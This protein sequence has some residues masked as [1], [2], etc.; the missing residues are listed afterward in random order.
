[1]ART[2]VGLLELAGLDCAPIGPDNADGAQAELDRL[3]E[4]EDDRGWAPTQDRAIG[5]LGTLQLQVCGGRHG[6]PAYQPH[7]EPDE[8][9]EP[10][11]P[12]RPCTKGSSR[13]RLAPARALSRSW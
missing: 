11:P 9:R 1:M 6:D 7:A 2:P 13:L 4:L 3:G 5:G 10:P 8:D 12:T